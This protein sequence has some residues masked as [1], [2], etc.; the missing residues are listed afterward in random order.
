VVPCPAGGPTDV[1]ARV[2]A[3][4]MQA[5]LGQPVIVENAAGASGSIGVG[6]VARTAPDGYTLSFGTWSTHVVNGVLLAL[7]YSPLTD[8][9]PVGLIVRS[10]MLMTASKTFA[11]ADLQALIA[12]LKANPDKAILGTPG[13]ASAS[14]L[15]G[16]F[17]Q[18]NTG[19]RLHVVPYRGVGPA[20]QD[21]IG[22]RVDLMIDLVAN[23]LPHVRAGTIKA[24]AVLAKSRLDTAPEIPTV[25]EA[26]VPGL[27]VASWQAVWA[28]KGTPPAVIGTLNAAILGALGDSLLRQR[29]A[30][31]AQDIPPL[32]E[33][34]PQALG[35]LQRAEIEKWSA[36]IAAAHIKAP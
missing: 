31:M 13:I 21:M 33:L 27:H 11:A 2:V 12:W 18:M 7:P 34:T 17:F 26:G 3:D 28:P 10:P 36:I 30:N 29:L 16:V 24:L 23:S 22:G 25:D 4:R 19:T 20:L 35:A 15:A 8:F 1:I 32:D 6:R 5:Q 9:E 14:H